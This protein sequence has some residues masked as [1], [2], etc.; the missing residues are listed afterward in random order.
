MKNALNYE[1]FL[2]FI[3][4]YINHGILSLFYTLFLIIIKFTYIFFY[5]KALGACCCEALRAAFLEWKVL[6]KYISLL[7][8]CLVLCFFFFFYYLYFVKQKS[9]S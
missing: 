3:L 7:L 1:L 6:H 2:F 5:V 9:V 4:F 8:I